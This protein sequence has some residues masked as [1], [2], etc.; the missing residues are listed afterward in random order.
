[1]SAITEDWKTAPRIPLEELGEPTPW[2]GAQSEPQPLI[3][4]LAPGNADLHETPEKQALVLV[5]DDPDDLFFLKR[6]LRKADVACPIYSAGGGCDTLRI[7]S[8]L[9]ASVKRIC[10]VLDVKLPDVSGF[11]LLASIRARPLRPHLKV[12]FLTGNRQPRLRIRANNCGADGFFNKP[13]WHEDWSKV[14]CALRDLIQ[15]GHPAT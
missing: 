5:D 6:A 13:N 12:V 3:G 11:E 4:L 8:Q 9:E 1:M 14:A 15:E 7:L 2:Q 10:L